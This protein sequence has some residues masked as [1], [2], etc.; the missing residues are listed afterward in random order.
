MSSPSIRQL[1][2][3]IFLDVS[4]QHH[5]Q[6]VSGVHQTFNLIRTR[7]VFPMGKDIRNIKLK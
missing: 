1:M 2:A 6:N 3:E 7:D 4:I 5:T